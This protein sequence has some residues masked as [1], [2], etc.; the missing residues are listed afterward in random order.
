VDIYYINEGNLYGCPHVK[1]QIG[2][3]E[4]IAVLDSGADISILSEALFEY[5]T[6]SGL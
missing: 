3:K 2:D 1:L 6:E 4:V 5:L